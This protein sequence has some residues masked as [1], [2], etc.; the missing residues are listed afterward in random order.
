MWRYFMFWEKNFLLFFRLLD[1]LE[2]FFC[3]EIPLAKRR[4]S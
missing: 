1:K 3:A 2:T 4:D